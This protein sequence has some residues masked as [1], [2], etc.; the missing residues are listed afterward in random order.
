MNREEIAHR[1]DDSPD[2]PASA[3]V[4]DTGLEARDS[5]SDSPS[6]LALV[7]AVAAS[8]LSSKAL[9][10]YQAYKEVLLAREQDEAA[11]IST[12]TLFIWDLSES[13]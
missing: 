8:T 6:P 12:L 3:P 4:H 13:R 7:D 11:I 9:A 5:A 2:Q 10:R 1:S